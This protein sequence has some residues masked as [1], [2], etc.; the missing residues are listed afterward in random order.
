MNYNRNNVN[1]LLSKTSELVITEVCRGK[2]TTLKHKKTISG[3]L[4][5]I[6]SDVRKLNLVGEDLM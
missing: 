6:V 2:K 5:F 3:R 4:D 1:E